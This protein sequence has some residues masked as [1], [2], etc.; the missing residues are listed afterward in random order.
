MNKTDTFKLIK[1]NRMLSSI[2][3]W[4]LQVFQIY[5]C[6]YFKYITTFLASFHV[7]SLKKEDRPDY[8][9]I[10]TFEDKS[11]CKTYRLMHYLIE[12]AFFSSLGRKKSSV[13]SSVRFKHVWLNSSSV[14]LLL[15]LY[16]GDCHIN[17]E[18]IYVSF[19]GFFFT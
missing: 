5:V 11:E 6:R 4:C 18:G 1:Y 3:L 8:V 19:G 17:L 15:R 7:F 13:I 16:H 10:S 2:K 9:R 14:R 12:L